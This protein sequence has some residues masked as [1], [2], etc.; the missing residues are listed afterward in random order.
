M[1]YSFAYSGGTIIGISNVTNNAVITIPEMNPDGVT[2]ITTIQSCT[3][4]GELTNVTLNLSSATYLTTIGTDAFI[5]CPFTGALTI[6]STVT[7]IGPG[8]FQFTGFTT[9]SIGIGVTAIPDFCFS[10]CTFWFSWCWLNY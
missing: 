4:S 10:N 3:F 9:L 5:G 6:P 1:P 7:S 2:Q 8:A